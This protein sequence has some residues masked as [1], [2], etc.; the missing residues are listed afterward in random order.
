MTQLKPLTHSERYARLV[1]DAWYQ[2]SSSE[3]QSAVE[4]VSAGFG[5]LPDAESERMDLI[6]DL[7][8]RLL[9][10]KTAGRTEEDAAVS[11]AIGLVSHLGRCSCRETETFTSTRS[12]RFEMPAF[13]LSLRCDQ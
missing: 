1:L 10:W 8:R 3:L 2:D 7:S 9:I 6:Q 4:R 12:L 13:A 5:T 11:A